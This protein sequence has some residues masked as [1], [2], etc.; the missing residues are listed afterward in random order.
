MSQKQPKLKVIIHAFGLFRD[1][2]SGLHE[3]PPRDMGGH[4]KWV[5]SYEMNIWMF[6]VHF[7]V[8]LDYKTNEQIG[9]LQAFQGNENGA[10]H[11]RNV[12]IH[13]GTPRNVSGEKYDQTRKSPKMSQKHPKLKVIIHACGLFRSPSSIHHVMPPRDMEGHW[14]WVMW[15]GTNIWM[16]FIFIW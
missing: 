6:Y 5:M 13:V 9:C 15:L 8:I 7:G 16:P 12:T 2:S 11:P 4:W 3:M 10:K 14:K 1:P